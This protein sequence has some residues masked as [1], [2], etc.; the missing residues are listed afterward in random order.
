[1][2]AHM[3][4]P[5]RAAL[6]LLAYTVYIFS[7]IPCTVSIRCR[8]LSEDQKKEQMNSF[9]KWAEK[10]KNRIKP[11]EIARRRQVFEQQLAGCSESA[12]D[13]RDVAVPETSPSI[14]PQQ[15]DSTPEEAVATPE[16]PE[17]EEPPANSAGPEPEGP[18]TGAAAQPASGTARTE[19]PLGWSCIPDLT[20]RNSVADPSRFE[21]VC[22]AGFKDQGP[23]AFEDPYV[24]DLPVW[25]TVQDWGS[26][27]TGKRVAMVGDSVI[28]QWM[29][30]TE[31]EGR[32]LGVVP[33]PC[34][35][36]LH[37]TS[38]LRLNP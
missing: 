6:L 1:M 16:D 30:A 11:K 15:P 18:A 37:S 9:E 19:L 25:Y 31:C 35:R 2:P 34:L 10:R 12:E 21:N 38:Y 7:E 33:D 27:L 24:P 17:P 32:R 28:N 13:K 26:L 14:A 29:D 20:H 22:T 36:P 3:R 5:K 23:W 4:L 8:A